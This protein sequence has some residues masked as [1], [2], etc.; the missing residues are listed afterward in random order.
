MDTPLRA[1]RAI[2]DYNWRD[3]AEDAEMNGQEG[4]PTHI[5]TQ[6]QQ[7]DAWLIEQGIE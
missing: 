5:F 1:I 4:D 3:E 6:L 7:V 2:V